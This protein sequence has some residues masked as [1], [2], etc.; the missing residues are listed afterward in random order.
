MSNGTKGYEDL[1][2]EEE[3]D[4]IMSEGAGAVVIDFWSPSCGPCLAMAD[5]FA[6]VAGQF[7]KEEVRF[8]KVDT[9]TRG[10]LA[11]PFN[12]RSVPTILFIKNGEVVDAVVGRMSAA[13][14]GKRA[15][16]LLEKTRKRGLLSR[17]RGQ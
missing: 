6:H 2:T 16:W 5:D 3:M 14:L 9:A 1:D 11:A 10:W 15:E 8:F 17:L 7:D 13:Q 4:A 12:I